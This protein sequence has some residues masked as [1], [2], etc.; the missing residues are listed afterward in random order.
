MT[1]CEFLERY[2][3]VR[4]CILC[5]ERL[6]YEYRNEA[7]CDACRISFERAKTECCPECNMSMS[8]CR[9][10]PKRLSNVGVIEH[11]KLFAYRKNEPT[12]PENRL[13]L[14]LKDNKVG[15][16][17]SFA[18]GQLSHR[19]D[20]L[21]ASEKL[22]RRDVVIT[23][24]PR[25][26]R[27]Y[28]RYGIDQARFVAEALGD[29]SRIPCVPLVKRLHDGKPQK[30]LSLNERL[31]NTAG[32]FEV[33]ERCAREV[34]ARAVIL[35]DD[36][37]TTGISVSRAAQELRRYGFERIYVLSLATVPVSKR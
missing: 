21:L 20:E 23:F 31:K 4:K 29:V 2:V 36:V 1:L 13:V 5:G 9:C 19:L 26:R 35:Y 33:N 16:V 10:L 14:Y 7:F 6:G 18:A 24:I 22:D 25:S 12:R 34:S 32:M 3:F 30:K 11:R 27:S 37:V 8:D 17:A 15:R 28:V